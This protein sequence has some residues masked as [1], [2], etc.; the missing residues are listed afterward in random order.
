MSEKE[1]TCKAIAR[2]LSQQLIT[3]FPSEGKNS[4]LITFPLYQLPGMIGKSLE[5]ME[6]GEIPTVEKVF[7]LM[8]VG[9]QE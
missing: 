4:P 5:I 6:A 3:S 9:K 2:F 8:M 1:E 7:D